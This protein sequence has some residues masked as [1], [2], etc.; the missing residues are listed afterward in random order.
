[1]VMVTRPMKIGTVSFKRVSSFALRCTL[2]M[3]QS[4][5]YISGESVSGREEDM[6]NGAAMYLLGSM[7]GMNYTLVAKKERIRDIR[8]MVSRFVRSRSYR[9]FIFAFVGGVRT[10]VSMDFLELMASESFS[11]RLR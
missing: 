2:F 9:Y 3:Q 4:D 8:D 11:N 10:D 1:M 5:S 6:F 7:D